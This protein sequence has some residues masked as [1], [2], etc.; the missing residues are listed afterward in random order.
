MAHKR[1]RAVHAFH[2]EEDDDLTIEEGA[3]IIATE[4]SEDWWFGYLEALG[5]ESHHGSFPGNYVEELGGAGEG[6]DGGGLGEPVEEMRFVAMHSHNASEPGD[7]SFR[8][9]EVLI[10]KERHGEWWTGYAESVP[11]VVGKFPANYVLEEGKHQAKSLENTLLIALHDF[12]DGDDDELRFSKGDLIMGES[13]SGGWW[14]GTHRETGEHGHFPANYVKKVDDDEEHEE[15]SIEGSDDTDTASENDERNDKADKIIIRAEDMSPGEAAA[16]IQRCERGRCARANAHELRSKHHAATQI[17]AQARGREARQDFL[18]QKGAATHIQAHVRGSAVRKQYPELSRAGRQS[19][20]MET[21]K[22]NSDERDDDNESEVNYKEQMKRQRD[23]YNKTKNATPK[24]KNRP[25]RKDK[26]RKTLSKKEAAVKIQAFA[27]GT[28]AREQVEDMRDLNSAAT[29]IQAQARGREAREDFRDQR[30]AAVHI[31]SCVRGNRVRSQYPELA[32][33]RQRLRTGEK[34]KHFFR[35]K[36]GQKHRYRSEQRAPDQ[37]RGQAGRQDALGDG[38]AQ[39]SR[40]GRFTY[41]SQN[42]NRRRRPDAPEMNEVERL[43]TAQIRNFNS[44]QSNQPRRKTDMRGQIGY[45][46]DTAISMSAESV[47]RYS[48]DDDEQRDRDEAMDIVDTLAELADQVIDLGTMQIEPDYSLRLPKK[49]AN[50]DMIRGWEVRKYI[51]RINPRDID[52]ARFKPRSPRSPNPQRTRSPRQTSM[53]SSYHEKRKTPYNEQYFAMKRRIA[54]TPPREWSGGGGI[55][56]G[57]MPDTPA[58]RGMEHA[59]GNERAAYLKSTGRGEQLTTRHNIE[60]DMKTGDDHLDAEGHVPERSARM[61]KYLEKRKFVDDDLDATMTVTGVMDNSEREERRAKK[62]RKGRKGK[63]HYM[64]SKAWPTTAKASRPSDAVDKSNESI[65]HRLELEHVHGFSAQ[66]TRNSLLYTVNGNIL[67]IAAALAVVMNTETKQQ[68]FMSAHTDDIMSIASFDVTR[69]RKGAGSRGKRS[70]ASQPYTLVATG[71]IGHVPKIIIWEASRMRVLATIEGAHERGVVQLAFSPDGKTLASIGLDNENSLALHN[72]RSGTLLAKVRTGGDKVFGLIFKPQTDQA[73]SRVNRSSRGTRKRDVGRSISNH[74]NTAIITCGHKHLTFWQRPTEKTLKDSSAR[75]GKRLAGSVSIVDVCFDA[76]GRIIAATS[77]GHLC[78]WLQTSAML[79]LG[80]GSVESAHGNAPINSVETVLP[81]RDRILSGGADGKVILWSCPESLKSLLT[82]LATFDSFADIT[83]KP[84]IQ[85]ISVHS[86]GRR[87][88]LGTRGGEI[89]EISLADGALLSEEPLTS[90]HNFGETWGLAAHP[91]DPNVFATSGDDKT[92]RLWHVMYRGSFARTAP[93]SVL[94]MSR[95]LCFSPRS[96]AYLV[97]GL[98]GRIGG[99]KTGDFG[100]HAGKIQIFDG[101]SL[102]VLK[103]ASVAKEQISD[104]AF[105]ND[106]KTLAVASNDNF[107]H[108]IDF[109][110]PTR[111][112]RRATCKGHSSYVTDISIS[113]DSKYMM[114]NCG[115]GEILFWR[116]DNGKRLTKLNKLKEA[117]WLPLTCPLSYATQGIWPDDGDLTD[118]N[119]VMATKEYIVCA[120]DFGNVRLFNSPS[121]NWCAP[122]MLHRGHSSHVTNVC[123]NADKSYVISV[124]GNDR[125]VFLW[126]MVTQS[127]QASDYDSDIYEEL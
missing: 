95:A 5:P 22:Q 84:S 7:L 20:I 42:R 82:P 4:S 78:V 21:T 92:I 67:Y 56:Q 113:Q 46:P 28:A 33:N 54:A 32:G 94:D 60:G 96:G 13:I 98:G 85:S 6:N 39:G 88:L 86:S 12:H 79:P 105:S 118:I 52:M 40:L 89:M 8:S 14:E 106:G 43:G 23:Y 77:K 115:A 71:E 125:C 27:R 68:R 53:L 41:T 109:A 50:A 75:F 100:K 116:L 81:R 26:R 110:G 124:G 3:I 38:N 55:S 74:G 57:G 90:S 30:G 69:K 73:K 123:F 108:L 91:H 34:R 120:D 99:R 119:A 114:S 122:S 70:G 72:W 10:G 127:N 101:E 103:T 49:K 45:R 62:G 112:K 44:R 18:D 25:H 66:T 35:P 24:Y 117:E 61:L 9:G 64:M 58:Q 31:Q 51:N 104:V 76:A 47:V 102:K 87:I 48:A 121:L 111:L 59:I 63:A 83:T 19:G 97:A 80:R 15:Q 1:C 17:Q 36:K 11:D 93:G 16:M 126:K 29:M 2:A 37:K 65:P 107:I